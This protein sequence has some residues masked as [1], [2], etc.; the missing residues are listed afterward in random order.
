LIPANSHSYWNGNY[1]L[2]YCYSDVVFYRN[3]STC[4]HTQTLTHSYPHSHS[5]IPHRLILTCSNTHT[6]THTEKHTKFIYI[7]YI[8]FSIA[9]KNFS[10]FNIIPVPSL[11]NDFIYFIRK[12]SSKSSVSKISQLHKYISENLVACIPHLNLAVM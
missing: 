4:T 9:L 3:G 8:F 1:L 10:L 11:I 7:R 5:R 2:V 12:L 6:Y